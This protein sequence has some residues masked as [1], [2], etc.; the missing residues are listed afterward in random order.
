MGHT[1]KTKEP[2]KWIFLLL[3]LISMLFMSIGYAGINSIILDLTGEI[4]AE[5][6]EGIFITDVSYKD[7][8][9]AEQ[10][11]QEIINVYKTILN[12]KINL[13]ETLEDSSITYNITVY[14]K[15]D[16]TYKFVG[17]TYDEDVYSNNNITFDV[18]GIKVGDKILS[19]KSLT[20]SITFKYIDN[21][22][23]T[24]ENFNNVLTS[25]L[26][27]N[28]ERDAI[29][30][31]ANKMIPIYY[32]SGEWKKTTSSSDNWHDYYNGKWVNALTY[33]HNLV[34]NQ[35]ENDSE[36]K[37][38]NGTSD[39]INLGSANYNFGT[40]ITLMSRF[41][42]YEYG[43][44]TQIIIGNIET[45]GCYLGLTSGNRIRFRVNNEDGTNTS[46]YSE[47]KIDLDT[48]YTVVA[49]C[50][51]AIMKLYIDGILEDSIEF[52]GNITK[53][54]APIM[55]GGNPSTT[56]EATSGYFGGVISEVAIMKE[57]LTEV[58]VAKNYGKKL[59]HIPTRHNVLYYLKF[60][61]DN[62]IVCNSPSYESEGM[63][64]D[65][66]DDYISV[67]YSAYNFNN[68][69]SIGARFKLRAYSDQE[70]DIFGN[71]QAAGINL[72]KTTDNKLQVAI[73]NQKASDYVYRYFSVTPELETWYT[74]I[75]TY[76]GKTLKLY[77]DGK[78]DLSEDIDIEMYQGTTPFMIGVNPNLN[79]KLGGA[80]FNGIISDVI[81][82]DEAL[83]ADQISTYYSSNLRTVISDKTLISY[84]LRAYESRENGT[85]IP[86]EMINTMWV[87]IPRFVATT[88]TS[89]GVIDTEIVGINDIAHDAFS[90]GGEEVEGFWVGKFENS[91]NFTSENADNTIY[92]KPNKQSWTN[93]SIGGMFNTIKNI[94]LLRD[95]YGFDVDDTKNLDTHMIKNNEWGA[96][97]YFSHGKCGISRKGTYI[98][99]EENNTTK[100]LTGG[101]NYKTNVGQSS[102]GNVYG[103]Y[104]MAGGT[105]EFVMGNYNSTTNSY[106]ETL[107]DSKYYN[108]Y[109][110]QE[111]YTNNDLQHTLFETNDLYNKSTKNFV[112]ET[113]IWLIR[114]NLFSYN[115]SS[116]SSAADI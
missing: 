61:A 31:L 34:Y 54:A 105:S 11:N 19:G 55:I 8:I 30:V 28:F 47:E 12:S 75:A 65:G 85:I 43:T 45:T 15:I 35:A 64:F 40:D 58:E 81:L 106:L 2:R 60:D 24:E 63:A 91:T 4:I 36:I 1:K 51:G 97:A 66:L 18:S 49:T 23:M 26:D 14:N 9:N 115:S 42:I 56:G 67:G 39:Y 88:P 96:I 17:V 5:A 57:P 108:I 103:I 46:L 95:E 111:K 100:Y 38:F 22:D 53:S 98:E 86:E 76:D 16:T 69:F 25:V 20:F 71:P 77:L 37:V 74:I 29:P 52:T 87:W 92:I 116:G 89:L 62:G 110:T 32:E 44:A 84:D 41:K 70:Y 112:D 21:I 73:Y 78:E 104:D 99:V 13:S 102:T 109:T 59:N 33:N 48:W 94:I 83:T 101:D 79:S 107:P 90:I 27:F 7:S 113:N 93:N 50:D 80:Y 82:V 3:I 72:F 6:Q 68:T 10:A 114:N